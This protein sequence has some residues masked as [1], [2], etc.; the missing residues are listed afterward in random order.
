MKTTKRNYILFFYTYFAIN[1]VFIIVNVF[2][3]V[4]FF[5]VFNVSRVELAFIQFFAYLSLFS[6]PLIAIYFDKERSNMRLLVIIS[7]IGMI[8]SFLLFILNLSLLIV[9]GIF[10][11]IYFVCASIVRVAIDKIFVSCSPDNKSK[12]RNSAYMQVGAITG[13]LLPNVFAIILFT[14]IYS[15][16]LW[17]IFFL[18]SIISVFPIII[19]ISMVR[20][21]IYGIEEENK[22]EK[23]QINK[24]G[25]ILVSILLFLIYADNIYQY[26][27][28]PWILDTYGAEN[29]TLI[30]IFFGIVILLNAVGVIL[31]GI[32]SNKF[33]RI[34]VLFI[35]SL[36]FGILLI[37]APFTNMVLFFTLFGI[38]NIC[39]GFIIVNM[40]TLVNDYSQKRV[41]HYQ[42]MWSFG[43]L[44]VVI[45]IPV[46]TYLSAFIATEIIIVIGGIFRLIS[47]IPIYLLRKEI[48][49]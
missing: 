2:L 1:V 42:I 31:A 12:D 24:R 16:P 46:G 19:I 21:D 4:Y 49:K 45:F 17:N 34:K 14:D 23:V 20:F 25:I 44:A 48:K 9:F 33:D 43:L 37:I 47:L 15:V 41:L 39:S 36:I 27:L 35:A 7:S 18:V 10:L 26:P 28:E 29:I 11:A 3:P 22:R 8:T 5:N 6:K 38:I 32:F 13:A 40:M 30:L